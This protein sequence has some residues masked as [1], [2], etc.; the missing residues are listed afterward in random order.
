MNR[1]RRFGDRKDGYRL[2]TISPMSKVSPYIMKKRSDAQN[3]LRD[4]VEADNIR[5][6]IHEKRRQGYKSFGVLHVIV[7]AY[8]RTISQRPAINRFIAGQRIYS[9]YNIEGIMTVKTQM[10]L[11]APDT[12]IKMIFRPD[13]TADEVYKIFTE[14]TDSAKNTAPGKSAFDKTAKALTFIPGLFLTFT[15]SVLKLMD[16]FGLLPKF[17]LDVSPFHGSFV[18]TSMGSLGIPPIFHH[19]YDF[20][21]CPVFIAY[22][23]YRGELELDADGRIIKKRYLDFT[24]VTDERICDGFYFASA[25]KLMRTY[26]ENPTLLDT[27]PEKVIT[28][29][30]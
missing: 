25:L 20:G 11:D 2:R 13:V 15:V 19:L 22:G 27:P 9:R 1:K 7:A 29:I 4:H 5:K 23:R 18:I 14:K 21:N 3:Y 28:D 17:L 8:I 10:T 30:E 24:A 16:Y 6:Y 26:L 12:E